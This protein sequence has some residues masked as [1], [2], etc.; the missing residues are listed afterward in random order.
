MTRQSI[1]RRARFLLG[2]KNAQRDQIYLNTGVVDEGL[3]ASQLKLDGVY[4]SMSEEDVALAEELGKQQNDADAA[5]LDREVNPPKP[6]APGGPPIKP[7]GG[8]PIWRS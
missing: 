8:A 3:V 2:L 6:G 4:A 1:A 5:N 7:N